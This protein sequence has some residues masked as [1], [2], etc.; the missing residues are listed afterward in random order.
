MHTTLMALVHE[1][2]FVA[3][4]A[5]DLARGG[6]LTDAT[7]RRLL[8]AAGRLNEAAGLVHGR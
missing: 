2:V 4:V 5:C 8:T 6:V 3:V 1:A 7:R